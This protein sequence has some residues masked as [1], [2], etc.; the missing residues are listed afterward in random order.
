MYVRAQQQHLESG[1]PASL[2]VNISLSTIYIDETMLGG[3]HHRG[4]GDDVDMAGPTTVAS[5]RSNNNTS[6]GDW[7]T[8]TG[9]YT[10]FFQML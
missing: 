3:V 5:I 4:N 7:G 6:R 1:L 2:Q 9:I 8:R 10:C